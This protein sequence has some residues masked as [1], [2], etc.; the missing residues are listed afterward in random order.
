M[1]NSMMRNEQDDS[2]TLSVKEVKD[3]HQL[4]QE[5]EVFANALIRTATDK[6]RNEKDDIVLTFDQASS[7][8]LALTLHQLM[9]LLRTT[10][11]N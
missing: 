8:S 11:K 1:G 7:I 5:I 3:Q 4:I 6:T 2:I 10:A 9:S